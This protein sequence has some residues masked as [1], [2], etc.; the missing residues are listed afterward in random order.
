MNLL[1][2]YILVSLAFFISGALLN[3][4]ENQ[5]LITANQAMLISVLWPFLCLAVL[6]MT[7][8]KSLVGL[9]NKISGN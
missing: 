1:I 8:Y 6:A 3:Q 7:V 5:N 9:F 4:K 2:I